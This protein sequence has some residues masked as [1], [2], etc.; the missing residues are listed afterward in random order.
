MITVWTVPSNSHPSRFA[1]DCTPADESVLGMERLL[2]KYAWS[3]C[4]W[5]SSY[6]RRENFAFSDY[7]VLDFDHGMTLDTAINNV[8]CDINH[9]IGTTKSHQKEKNGVVCDRFRVV[10]KLS[11]RITDI[12]TYTS[13]YRYFAR[14]WESDLSCTDAARFFYPCTSISSVLNEGEPLEID[15]TC[16][17]EVGASSVRKSSV[18][19]NTLAAW[20]GQILR[21]GIE[22]N[23]NTAIYRVAAHAAERGIE[24]E[25]ILG[26]ILNSKLVEKINDREVKRV[27]ENGYRRGK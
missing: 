4:V 26:M 25:T 19:S 17:A 2:V 5:R 14:H 12:D 15:S 7:L 20:A 1:Q 16:I 10:L 21:D 3:P 8:F 22:H 9:V 13:V 11:E 23:S 24:Y 18:K 6:R 27:A